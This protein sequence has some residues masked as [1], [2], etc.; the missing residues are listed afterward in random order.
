M[1]SNILNGMEIIVGGS[2]IIPMDIR[3]DA[4][5][6]SIM[7][8][9]M[10]IQ[11]PIINACLSSLIIKEGITTVIGFHPPFLQLQFLQYP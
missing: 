6:I 11:K 2:I 1:N 4:T 5:T 8:N 7:I 3:V 9:G 10:Y